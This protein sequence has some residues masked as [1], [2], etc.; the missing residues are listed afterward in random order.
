MNIKSLP[1]KYVL[2]RWTCAARSGTVQDNHGRNVIENPK[3][4]E[5]LCYKDM[6]R[7]FLNLA[8]RA[9]SHPGCTLLINNTLDTLSK[10]VEE[11]IIQVLIQLFQSLLPQMLVLLQM[12]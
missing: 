6:T 4:N 7:R 1:S 5:M 9:A 11:E 3:L 8:L 12:I 2:K 10:Q